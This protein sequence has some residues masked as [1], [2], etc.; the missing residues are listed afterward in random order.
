MSFKDILND[1]PTDF[2]MEEFKVK[3]I[4]T[5]NEVDSP[6]ILEPIVKIHNNRFWLIITSIYHSQSI[7]YLLYSNI[8]TFE[9]L[10]H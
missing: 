7:N 5:N 1:E 9:I 2:N 6:V 8:I 10:I 3:E 4:D